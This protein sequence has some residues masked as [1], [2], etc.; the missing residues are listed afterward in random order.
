MDWM[1]WIL[2][3]WNMCDI[4]KVKIQKCRSCE[5]ECDLIRPSFRFQGAR[6]GRSTWY[7]VH[8]IA[9]LCLQDPAFLEICWVSNV[10][11][12]KTQIPKGDTESCNWM[13]WNYIA[14]LPNYQPTEFLPLMEEVLLWYRAFQNISEYHRKV[15]LLFTFH[16]VSLMYKG[17]TGFLPSTCRLPRNFRKLRTILQSIC[18]PNA[19]DATRSIEMSRDM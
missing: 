8:Q 6:N 18:Q 2:E 15:P 14:E 16:K 19:E 7:R 13:N 5:C 3:Q 12:V 10:F 4:F 1:K 9:S 11:C 17:G